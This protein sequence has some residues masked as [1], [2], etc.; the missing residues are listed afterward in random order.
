MRLQL[1]AVNLATIALV[2][3]PLPASAQ[4]PVEPTAASTLDH[5]LPA[6]P[7]PVAPPTIT[8]I[9]EGKVSYYGAA[10]AGRKT[11]NGERFLPDLLTMAHKT[12]QFGTLVRVTNLHNNLSVI[13]RVNDRGPFVGGRVGDVSAGAARLLGMLRAG[14]VHAR[15]EVL[16]R[17]ETQ[18]DK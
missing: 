1:L 2:L 7:P 15:L 13:V 17:G 6:P 16:G 5:T 11:S 3:I 4:E 8:G 9:F 18:A 10:F 14:V 12:L